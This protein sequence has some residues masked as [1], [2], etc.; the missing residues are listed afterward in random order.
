MTVRDAVLGEGARIDGGFAEGAVLLRGASAGA[1]AHLRAGT[2]MEE[3]SSTAHAV[4]LKHTILLAFVTLGSL[5]NFCDA[6]VAGGTS[7]RDHSEVGSGYIHFNYTPPDYLDPVDPRR[8]RNR[9]YIAELL[10]LRAW[11]REVR[12]PRIPLTETHAHRR[13]VI[14]EAIV[15]IELAIE[16]RLAR[17]RAFCEERGASALSAPGPTPPCPCRSP[18]KSPTSTRSPG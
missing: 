8:G 18:P 1:D 13:I 4:G 15:N 3:E 6:L 16:E 14:D 10:A 7:R 17:L 9:R 5:I 2:L 12:L 11:Y